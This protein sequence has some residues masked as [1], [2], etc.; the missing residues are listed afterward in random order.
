MRLCEPQNLAHDKV[1]RFFGVRTEFYNAVEKIGNVLVFREHARVVIGQT[2]FF[3]ITRYP[4][5]FKLRYGIRYS[6]YIGCAH[7]HGQKIGFGEIS[8]IVRILFRAHGI[9]YPLVIVETPSFLFH[10]PAAFQQVDLTSRLESDRA[11][12]RTERIEI[13][14]F[15]ARSEFFSVFT[16]GHRKIDVA[17]QRAFLHFH[18]GYAR[19]LEHALKLCQ[20]RN[21]FLGGMH[22]R[23]CNYLYERH[24]ATVV[25]HARNTAVVNELARVFFEMYAIEPHALFLAV[26]LEL[27]VPAYTKRQIVLT[28]LPRLGQIG[29][30]I[31]LSVPLGKLAYLAMQRKPRLYRKFHGFAIE[32]G[33]R[34]RK[35]GTHGTAMR[36]RIAA[37]LVFATAKQF[38]FGL[39]LAMYFTAYR[40]FKHITHISLT[41]CIERTVARQTDN[42]RCTREGRVLKSVRN[43]AGAPNVVRITQ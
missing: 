4:S 21:D 27:Y 25:I 15:G 30:K 10:S 31:I 17:T 33:Q 43:R 12:D 18:V 9:A 8:V 24:A 13:F 20:K 14:R 26:K 19:V 5:V 41:M 22:V 29:I 7:D 39:E 2:E 23:L 28:C 11:R 40:R 32:R 37:E 3:G 34:T 35:S 16:F 42:S 36:V 38:R 1:G 6:F